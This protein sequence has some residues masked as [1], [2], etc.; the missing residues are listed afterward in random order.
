[1]DIAFVSGNPHLPQLVGGIE[2]NTHELAGE[3]IRQ[4]N[5][6]SVLAKLS[7][8]S[9][10][11][12]WR[13]ARIALGNNKTWTDHEL[14]YP[15]YRS[16]QPWNCSAVLPRPT[17]A[18][19]QN[20]P[21][22]DF[23]TDFARIGVP[24]IAYLHGL[25]F[26]SWRDDSVSGRTLPFRGYIANSCFTAERF[27]HLYGLD[28]VVLPPL[29]R[30]ERYA[31]R[32]TGSMVTFVNPVPV[33]GVDLALA[34]AA[35]CPE[36]PFCFV[37]GWPLG[38]WGLSDLKRRVRQLDNVVLRRSTSDMRTVYRETR[39]LLVPSQ[40]EDET[41]GRVVS[42][43][44]FSGIPVIASSRGG[45]PEAVGPGG[46]ILGYD[47]PAEIWAAAIREVWSDE[48]RYRQL[49]EAAL[50]HAAR[51]DLDPDRQVASLISA[52]QQFIA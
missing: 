32:V 43:A 35:L 5:R 24:S 2:I 39:I 21:M 52:L 13:A 8:R 37:R 44:Q 17:V 28:A 42:E 51:P 50:R 20:G 41:W 40:W 27:R 9:S 46:M 15:V 14:G 48:Q 22:L 6:V 47:Q 18:I 26:Q 16:R 11:G 49:S 34:I 1:V 19:V 33:K 25:G 29:V 45:L 30:R 23:A 7:L 4:G 38:L 31:T 3:L 36:I 12:V 10:F